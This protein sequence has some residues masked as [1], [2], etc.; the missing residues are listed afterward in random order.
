MEGTDVPILYDL[1][2]EYILVYVTMLLQQGMG[3]SLL[4]S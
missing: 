2:V 4:I 3:V 1:K